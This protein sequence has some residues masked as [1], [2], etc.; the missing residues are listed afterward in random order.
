MKFTY[1]AILHRQEDGH[2]QA[3]LPDLEGCEA[4]G[5]TLDEAVDEANAA[6]YRWIEAEM[7]EDDAA[8]PPVSD[9]ADLRVQDG[10][11][12]RN[13]CIN[14]RFNDGWDE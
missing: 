4:S 14:F 9:A 5:E 8:L 3:M 12:V 13:I 10:D 6:M 7:A 11:E 2:W 1:P